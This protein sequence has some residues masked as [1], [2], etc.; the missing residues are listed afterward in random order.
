MSRNFELLK[1]LEIEVDAPTSTPLPVQGPVGTAVSQSDGG[2]EMVR[3]VKSVFLSGAGRTLRQVLFCGADS[4]AGSSSVCAA[5]ALALA[6]SG[7]HAVCLVDANVRSPQLSAL[8]GVAN[9]LPDSTDSDG[10]REQCVPIATNLWLAPAG[11][12]TDERG[13][14][15]SGDA[16]EH[17][18]AKL[19]SAFGY[20]FIDGPGAGIDSDVGV[21]GQVADAA[22]LV[23]EANST[24]RRTAR[25]AKDNL[26]AAGISLLGTI[27][28]N[29]TFAIPEAL[30]RKL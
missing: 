10:G 16:L 3:L 11:L 26:D 12:L 5:A 25:K 30:Y 21:L 24:R 1:Q 15:V 9:A 29:R 19:K 4:D 18:F 8:L 2:E 28:N 7:S 14:L 6:A 23:I 27:L 22:I 17:V 13:V 20:I